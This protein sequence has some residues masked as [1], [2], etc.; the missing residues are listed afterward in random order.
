VRLCTASRLVTSD[1]VVMSA[2]PLTAGSA[3]GWLLFL[4]AGGSMAPPST[5]PSFG[6]LFAGLLEGI[7]WRWDGE[8]WCRHGYPSFGDPQIPAEVLFGTLRRFGV[9]FAAEVAAELH[10]SAPNAVHDVAGRVL[11]SGGGVWTTNIDLCVEAACERPAHRAGRPRPPGGSQSAEEPLLAPLRSAGPGTLV[12]FHGT[13]EDPRTLAFTDVELLAPL[14][15]RDVEHLV[16]WAAGRTFVLYGYRGADADLFGLLEEVFAVANTVIW[17]EPFQ[18]VR[19]EIQRT[20]PSSQ[21]TFLPDPLPE[22]DVLRATAEAFLEFAARAGIRADDVLARTMLES[23]RGEQTPRITL[24]TAPPAIVHARLVER[25]GDFGADDA[26]LARARCED[27]RHL[28]VRALP[29]YARWARTRSLYRGGVVASGVEWLSEHRS[30]LAALR[31]RVVH[32]YVITSA[33]ALRLLKRSL[34]EVDEFAR[35]AVDL[36]GE[37]TDYYYLAYSYRYAMRAEDAR[38]AA[39]RAEQGLSAAGEPERHAGAVLEQGC[40]AIYQGRFGDASRCAFELSQRTGR[41]AIPRWRA[42]GHWLEALAQCYKGDPIAARESVALA[43]ERFGEEARAGPLADLRTAE[44][45]ADRV[46][47]SQGQEVR[48]S[49]DLSDARELGG[50]YFDDRALLLAD[51]QLALGDRDAA[52]RLLREV[53]ADPSCRV[54]DAWAEFGL[55]E[56]DRLDGRRS[57]AAG[58]FAALAR[59][60]SERGAHWL[61]AQTA[62][63]LELCGDG[64]A[65]ATIRQSLPVAVRDAAQHAPSGEPRVLWMMTT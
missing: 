29:Q 4:G 54:A 36:R 13:A 38:R 6:E 59:F 62:T 28:R 22:G 45:L 11:G 31:P 18:A 8:R 27:A 47:I 23:A 60:A 63:A 7:G 57:E 2:G 43:A 12:K 58:R 3:S 17:F 5:L 16:R 42:W 37:P 24:Q 35:W 48:P 46:S 34:P 1:D 49:T 41:Y 30:V 61:H 55:S 32:G 40:A 50:R 21:I 9:A 53:A 14:D 20:F 10:G 51:V 39:D 52:A 56:L 44:L 65:A 26:A 33:H 64:G 15:R 19:R 25:F